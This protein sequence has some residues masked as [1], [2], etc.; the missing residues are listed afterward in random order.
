MELADRVLTFEDILTIIET[1]TPKPG[2][3][4]PYK[5]EGMKGEFQMRELAE[6]MMM[7]VVLLDSAVAFVG[8]VYVAVRMALR[9]SRQ[10]SN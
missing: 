4:G 7:G 6:R 1:V 10:N 5:K 9:H 8:L 2:K 3:R